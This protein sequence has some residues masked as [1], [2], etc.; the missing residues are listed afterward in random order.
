MYDFCDLLVHTDRLKQGF[1]SNPVIH[2]CFKRVDVELTKKEV[3]MVTYILHRG[4]DD[5]FSYPEM[6]F[7]MFGKQSWFN[8]KVKYGLTG[9]G[10]DIDFGGKSK[11]N[12]VK[13]II[14]SKKL[15]RQIEFYYS[16]L[17]AVQDDISQGTDLLSSDEFQLLFTR[18]GIGLSAS[19][20]EALENF[21]ST[22]SEVGRNM[23]NVKELFRLLP[24]DGQAALGKDSDKGVLSE[25][26]RN[27]SRP[28]SYFG[29]R[30][31]SLKTSY[32]S[33]GRQGLTFAW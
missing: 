29:P 27:R 21:H 6:I 23:M 18:V 10:F 32:A 26:K 14:I 13:R 17:L 33:S 24:D 8:V 12:E 28:T 4:D 19:D 15:Q 9:P 31:T 1:L 20:K 3:A 25:R 11:E 30:C 16:E 5:T 22:H 7:H 2:K